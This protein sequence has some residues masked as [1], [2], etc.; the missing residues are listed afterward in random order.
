[1]TPRAAA[2][3]AWRA[4]QRRGR[5][6]GA[7]RRGAEGRDALAGRN[8]SHSSLAGLVVPEVVAEGSRDFGGSEASDGSDGG[9]AR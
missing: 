9:A 5:G 7:G 3:R 8:G 4:R 6:G 2:R 1:M